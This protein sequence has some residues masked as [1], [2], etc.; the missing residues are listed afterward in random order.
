MMRHMIWPLAALGVATFALASSAGTAS[1]QQTSCPDS[2]LPNEI[3]LAAG[4]GQTAQLGQPFQTNFQVKLANRNG[5][6]ITGNLSGINITF[7]GPASG[8]SGVFTSSGWREATIGTD[9]NGV[10]TAPTFTAN[11]TAGA[12]TVFA[13]SEYGDVQFSVANTA[14]GV[15][16]SISA[17]GG[18]DQAATT[19]H[20]FAQPLQARVVDASGQ[21][22]QGATVSFS[23]VAGPTGASAAFLTGAQGSAAT[24]ASGVAISP[25]LLA[26]GIAGR[27]T[28]V[29][30]VSGVAA[31]A[32][33]RLDNHL[34]VEKLDATRLASNAAT[35]G[36]VYRSRLS[37]RVIDATG[38]PVEGQTVTFVLGTQD[39]ASA[40]SEPGAT[41]GDGTNQAVI[42]TD[43]TGRATSP[44][45][46]AN[47]V[48]GRFAATVT[49]PGS[50][51]QH[52]ALHNQAGRA[53]TIAVGA[54]SGEA[55]P[56][57][58]QFAVP[59][60]VTVYDRFENRV[61]GATVVFSAPHQGAT[62]FF[63]IPS[64][65]GAPKKHHT[66]SW[67]AETNTN[68]EG[69]AVAPPLVANKIV[70]GYL[71]RVAV[72]GSSARATFALVNTLTP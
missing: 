57:G 72:R 13:H 34:A 1:A 62:G 35:V 5:C 26:N 28:A 2:N 52:F 56:A 48:A 63:T 50:P 16:A 66:K 11:F 37:V 20:Q 61:S 12:Y 14:N 43:A 67:T 8:P 39:P 30:T 64:R 29:A 10:A 40:L 4:S 38:Q 31:V 3:V 19:S 44:R 65:R 21:P 54:A 25:P 18:S 49:T 60:A 22:V 53:A 45:F 33:F 32:A 17:A 68:A 47:H 27:F 46:A 36:T 58:T 51:A 24:N 15:P 7:D 41:F 59:L 70:G 55:T 42:V 69:I 23:L 9:S 71:V 6:P